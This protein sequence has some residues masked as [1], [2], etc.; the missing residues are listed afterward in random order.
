MSF[1]PSCGKNV[2]ES[3][4]CPDCGFSINGQPSACA[5]PPVQYIL[6]PMTPDAPSKGIAWLSFFFPLVGLILYLVYHDTKPLKAASAGK[7]ALWGFFGP[8]VVIIVLVLV[9]TL[10]TFFYF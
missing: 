10:I 9:L 6:K 8:L 1:C 4:F 5:Q 2:G 3:A 7:G